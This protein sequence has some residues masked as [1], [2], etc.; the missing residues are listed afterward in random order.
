MNIR[1][2]E[3]AVLKMNVP[4]DSYSLVG[5]S[6]S[7]RLCI[8]ANAGCWSVYYSEKGLRTEEEFFL[9]ETAACHAFM[10]R[11]AKMFGSKAS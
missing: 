8:E 6:P 2:L 5:G 11:L 1:E 4:E 10:A 3:S 7:E 9:S